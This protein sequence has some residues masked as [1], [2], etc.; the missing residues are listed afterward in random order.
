MPRLHSSR[1]RF[2]SAVLAVALLTSSVAARADNGQLT[3]KTVVLGNDAVAEFDFPLRLQCASDLPPFASIDSSGNLRFGPL[4]TNTTVLSYGGY[5]FVGGV[6]LFDADFAGPGPEGFGPTLAG[7]KA[8][9]DSNFAPAGSY[10]SATVDPINGLT[11]SS[12]SGGYVVLFGVPYYDY[13]T[14]PS[15]V[16]TG[17]ILGTIANIGASYA[18]LVLGAATYTAG[19]RAIVSRAAV[20]AVVAAS[21]PIY[22]AWD[23]PAAPTPH[24]LRQNFDATFTMRA[25]ETKTLSSTDVPKLNSTSTCELV[26]VD[27]RG[28]V[29]TFLS[30]A[31]DS[32]TPKPGVDADGL[33]RSAITKMFQTITVTHTWYGDL[34]VSTVVSGNPGSHVAIFEVSVD[35]G[36]GRPNDRFLLRDG[37]SKVYAN[38]PAGTRCAVSETK[39]DGAS[40]SYRDNTGTGAPVGP[41]ASLDGVVVIKPRTVACNQV[42]SL[43]KATPGG[44]VPVTTSDGCITSVIIRNDYGVGAVPSVAPA[45]HP[46]VVAAVPAQPASTIPVNNDLAPPTSSELVPLVDAPPIDAG[47]ALAIDAA[48]TFTG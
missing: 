37:Q 9:I 44:S 3:I 48:P 33:Y 42:G 21:P 29:T 45:A 27:N 22:V 26:A 30:T 39:S 19:N 18:D 43:T 11:H 1:G 36:V 46:P 8:V 2:L 35:C 16:P 31:S 28:G 23:W 40:V 32:A 10:L 13:R 7:T 14:P 25:G 5:I 38:I 20:A 17:S 24:N 41:T 15:Q 47:P 34:V 12:G 4:P 6:A